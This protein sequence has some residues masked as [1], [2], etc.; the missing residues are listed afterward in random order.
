MRK[1]TAAISALALSAIALTGCSTAP[2][3]SAG[4]ERGDSALLTNAMK[5]T[6]D[7]GAA[8][9]A[10]TTPVR[11]SKVLSDDLI[12]GHGLAVTESE[13]NVVGTITF[14][15]G[16]NG[17][18]LQNGA[19]VWSPKNLDQQFAGLGDALQCATQGSRVAFAVP[20]KNL[21]QGLAEQVGMSADD[22]LVGIVDLQEVLLPKATGADV[23][24]DAQGLPS[25]VRAPGGQ[26]GIIIP[27]GAA[28]TKTVAQT[29][30]R[31]EGA[32]VGDGLA[33][34]QYTSVGWAD[35]KEIDS[36]W[37]K[38][39]VTD[40]K[41]LPKEVM[42]QVQKATVGSQLM[43]VVPAKSGDATAYV[44]DVLGIVPPELTGK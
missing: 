40:A 28:P 5:V 38:G 23:F 4:C 41:T 18:V 25:V 24:N 43:V 42:D 9:V 2:G 14:L 15:N 26:P 8:Q 31:G 11:T 1:T 34:F 27:D 29:L 6:G 20:A 35:R 30:I 39:V 44:V 13:Q 16:A 21:P 10:L 32:K 36:S 3:S 22:S 7:L 12:T 17:Q 19:G 33:M 37:T